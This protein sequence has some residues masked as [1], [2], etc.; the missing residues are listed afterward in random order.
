MTMSRAETRLPA[1]ISPDAI[2]LLRTLLLCQLAELADQ[3]AD[4]RTTVDE[5]AGR[6]DNDSVLERELAEASALRI[7]ATLQEARDA[8]RRI[9]D[10]TYGT[11][12]AC[13]M[14]I[15]YERL[16]SIPQVRRC[17]TCP[18]PAGLVG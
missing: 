14:P 5:P 10:G 8:L 6:S 7:A 1:H 9:D 3:V 2:V 17:V 16:E 13:A 4:S 12:E 15:P 11:C 18:A